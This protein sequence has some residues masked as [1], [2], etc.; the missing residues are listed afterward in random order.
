MRLFIA[1]GLSDEL[2][3]ALL[4]AAAELREYCPQANV[5][6]R[7]NMHLTLA[8]IGE[9]RRVSELKAIMDEIDVKPFDITLSRAGR[10]SE[11]YWAGL[12]P[13]QPLSQLARKL[14]QR[15]T[16]G[17]FDIDTKE[18]KPHITLAR[19]VDTHTPLPDIPRL[20][21]TV[22]GMTLM[23]SERIG[24]RLVYTPVYAR[25]FTG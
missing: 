18:F 21:Q 7:E 4:S 25:A 17:G 22:D 15:L 12:E 23:K 2:R 20:S 5:T 3:S 10:F 11:L 9:S 19:R 16:E 14:R 13:C 6:R 1:V 24:G 8:F